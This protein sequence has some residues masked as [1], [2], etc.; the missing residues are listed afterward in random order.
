MQHAITDYQRSFILFI[1]GFFIPIL[2]ASH[3]FAQHTDTRS[4]IVLVS[5]IEQN[6]AIFWYAGE[7]RIKDELQM[8]DLNIISIPGS[9]YASLDMQGELKRAAESQQTDI[10]ILIY[11]TDFQNARLMVYAKRSVIDAQLFS[12]YDFTHIGTEDAT[13]IVALKTAEI[14]YDAM[15]ASAE[16][17]PD[18]LPIPA[19]QPMAPKLKLA[20]GLAIAGVVALGVG[21]G[22]TGVYATHKNNLGK[23]NY[24]YDHRRNKTNT[25]RPDAVK[26]RVGEVGLVVGYSLGGI[27]LTASA[28]AMR[29]H[30]KEKLENTV[31]IAFSIRGTNVIWEF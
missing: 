17:V 8:S 30:R 22:F 12:E 1:T 27:L 13:D 5:M 25:E 14:V 31:P 24:D 16:T 10:A 23:W 19:K 4:G 9:P 11:K 26:A 20:L 2:F 7:Q 6:S 29:S 3:T 18:D 15:N 21:G 28:I